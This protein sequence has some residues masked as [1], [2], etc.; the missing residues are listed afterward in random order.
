[1]MPIKPWPEKL[2]RRY[3]RLGAEQLK[4]PQRFRWVVSRFLTEQK[5]KTTKRLE[6]LL[7]PT[8]ESEFKEKN[9]NATQ[10]QIETAVRHGLVDAAKQENEEKVT[11]MAH[12]YKHA[13]EEIEGKVRLK[14]LPGVDRALQHLKQQGFRI[15]LLT[16]TK[17]GKIQKNLRRMRLIKHF[18]MVIGERVVKKGR[19][20]TPQFLHRALNSVMQSKGLSELK[21]EHAMY[22]GDT[23]F[24]VEAGQKA[25][26]HTAGVLSGLGDEHVLKRVNPTF[27]SKDLRSL[28]KDLE[29]KPV[30]GLRVLFLDYGGVVANAKPVI[31][32]A[33]ERALRAGGIHPTVARA[34]AAVTPP[35]RALRA[36]TGH[37]PVF[38]LLYALA[39]HTE[40][41]S[42]LKRVER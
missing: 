4:K 29:Q 31:R 19:R 5:E 23:Q 38:K 3:V 17:R 2:V 41:R 28:A 12:A 20:A 9:P 1:M 10:E 14:A 21:P 18:D 34:V 16:K 25:G 11:F 26:M 37:E 7:R 22:V 42:G 35:V 33:T 8:L 13:R 39:R 24:D 36:F 30:S 40:E 15:V 6:P 27:L 32:K